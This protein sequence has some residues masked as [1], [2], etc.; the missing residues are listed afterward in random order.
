M[1]KIEVKFFLG[2][3]CSTPRLYKP[4]AYRRIVLIQQRRPENRDRP[5]FQPSRL[6]DLIKWMPA[7][8]S[9][10]CQA[11]KTNEVRANGHD[12]HRSD[13]SCVPPL[14]LTAFATLSKW[15]K[16]PPHGG[17][18]NYYGLVTAA[19][20]LWTFIRFSSAEPKVEA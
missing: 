13:L 7:P 20:I 15:G 11:S 17:D 2:Q 16:S 1:L 8:A 6:I 12:I 5:T 10:S 18:I 4:T 19:L 14:H 9:Q 3:P